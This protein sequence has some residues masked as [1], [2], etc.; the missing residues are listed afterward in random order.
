MR[1]GKL[2]GRRVA[3]RSAATLLLSLLS[4]FEAVEREI[5]RVIR[6]KQS[7]ST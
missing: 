7:I 6:T 4:L 1:F 2:P 5:V 3:L